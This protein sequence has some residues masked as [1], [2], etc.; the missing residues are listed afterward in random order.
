MPAKY[1]FLVEVDGIPQMGASKVDG[2][3]TIKHTPSKLDQGNKP[4]TEHDRGKYEVGEV[5]VTH[6]AGKNEI[7]KAVHQWVHDYVKGVDVSKRGARVI[8]MSNDG[9]TPVST[10]EL[11]NCV[12]TSFAHEGFDASSSDTSFFTFKFQPEDSDLL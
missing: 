11:L 4:N 1:Q 12:P 8:Q 6:A 10:Y 3:D 2:L 9:A 7:E 5:T